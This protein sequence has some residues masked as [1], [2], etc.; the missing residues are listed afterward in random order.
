VLFSWYGRIESDDWRRTTFVRKWVQDSHAREAAA[1]C[2]P[3]ATA[4]R[5]VQE[6][7]LQRARELGFI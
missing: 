7:D 3:G 6:M 4:Q 1:Y 5:F 2:E